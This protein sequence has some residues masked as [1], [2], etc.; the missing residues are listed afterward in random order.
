MLRLAGW[1]LVVLV[2]CSSSAAR[3]EPKLT[4]A[5]DARG[6][7]GIDKRYGGALALDLWAGS[8]LFRVGGTFGVGALSKSDDASSRVFT[9]FGLSLGIMPRDGQAGPTA[10]LRGGGYAGARRAG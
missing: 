7:V 2:L 1:L 3:A 10:V 9:P 8:G 5:V 6:L 4:G